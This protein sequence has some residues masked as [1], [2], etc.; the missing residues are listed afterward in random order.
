MGGIG[1]VGSLTPSS[2]D[3]DRFSEGLH[4]YRSGQHDRAIRL[5]SDLLA[6]DPRQVEA[7]HV[8]GLSLRA[9]GRSTESVIQLRVVVGTQPKNAEAW[10]NLGV[11]LREAGD[12]VGA[13][14]ALE[15]SAVLG[16]SDSQTWINLGNVE[17]DLGRFEEASAAFGKA[18]ELDPDRAEAHCGRGRALLE[19]GRVGEAKQ[20][21]AS[22]IAFD[23]G[24]AEAHNCMAFALASSGNVEGCLG[25][26][27]EARRL[28]PLNDSLSS[29][30]LL[31]S[32]ASDRHTAEDHANLARNWSATHRFQETA[33]SL[34]S[35]SSLKRIGFVSG[36][37]RSHPVGRIVAPVIERLAN[38]VEV[39]CYSSSP[40]E[41]DVTDRIRRRSGGFRNVY[42]VPTAEVIDAVEND[43]ID[44][45]VDLSGHTRYNR[46]DVFSSG[47]SALQVSWLGFPGT[48]GLSQM[49]ALLADDVLVPESHNPNYSERVVRLP[50][51]FLCVERA[52][53][54]TVE[55]AT[56][57]SAR[58]VFGVLNNPAK[59]S[60][61]CYQLWST[62]MRHMPDAELIVHFFN[63]E[64]RLVQHEVRRRFE[65]YGVSSDRL[66]FP[67][68]RSRTAR[69]RVMS[70]VDVALDTFPYTGAT[71]TLDCLFSGVPVVTL[72]GDR[73]SSRMSASLLTAVGLDSW[74]CESDVQYIARAMELAQDRLSLREGRSQL[75]ERALNSSLTDVAGFSKGLV[76]T[77]RT[78]L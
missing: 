56:E 62:V 59:F 24:S 58:P 1:I 48:T 18:L 30:V 28:S 55:P 47:T 43:E 61:S 3:A 73:Y 4:C 11:A 75:A 38:E 16:R 19:L 6:T 70:H 69:A 17:S 40:I 66:R 13:R 33:R 36:D 5:L 22:S 67:H 7:R 54:I 14:E 60:D 41:D 25:S 15:L 20:A 74:V 8:L 68:G 52:Q 57:A 53:Q 44:V 49:D 29:N 46:L 50:G 42:R 71:T 78:L 39:F 76:A 32:L 51:T 37:L 10:S 23:P 26:L 77:L 2:R 63:V 45:L 27:A 64:D 9:V 35:G 31:R 12:P 21:L 34:R 65:S 72:A